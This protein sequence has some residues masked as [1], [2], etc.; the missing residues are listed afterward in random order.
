MTGLPR[1]IAQRLLH[2][3]PVAVGVTFLVFLLLKLVPGDPAMAILGIRAT[4]EAVARLRDVLGLNRPFHL[5][6]LSFLA[7]L[8]R[9]DLGISLITRQPVTNLVLER[10]PP[11]LLLVI[12]SAVLSLILT[13]PPAIVAAR[14]KDRPADH[15]IRGTFLVGLAIPSFWLGIILILVFSLRLRLFPV[16]GYGDTWP[17]RIHHLFLPSFTVALAL[18]AILIRSLRAGL[19]EV[20]RSDYVRTAR[21]KGLAE[22][23][24]MRRHVLRNAA[25][26]TITILGVNLTYLVGGTVVIETVF[27]LPGVGAML[28]TAIYQRDYP[29][30][31]GITLA[32]A[33]LIILI[34][35]LVDL[36]Y[37]ALDPRITFD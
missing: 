1:F 10:L 14:R 8:V 19:L 3:V 28:V 5:Q 35:L 18:A 16:S 21:A 6:Y 30:V 34:N 37:V 20:L 11:T 7:S 2:L 33:V 22:G 4:P 13:V 29:V 23:A 24:V 9:G 36:A 15:V 32:F 17:D 31:Q 12:F 26:S 27:S 25:L